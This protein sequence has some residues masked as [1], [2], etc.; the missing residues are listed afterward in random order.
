M[1]TKQKLQLTEIRLRL[2]VG[3]SDYEVCFERKKGGRTWIVEGLYL[4]AGNKR[5]SALDDPGASF[6]LSAARDLLVITVQRGKLGG[7]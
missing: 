1:S 6:I 3:V 5:R 4:L 2:Q 7:L